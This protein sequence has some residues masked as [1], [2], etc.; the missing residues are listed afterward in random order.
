MRAFLWHVGFDAHD[1][2]LD[3]NHGDVMAVVGPVQDAVQRVADRT[4]IYSRA[5]GIVASCACIDPCTPAVE[6]VAVGSTH[7]GL[8]FD[9]DIYRMVG[10]RLRCAR[11][12]ARV[13]GA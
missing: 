2:G 7:L 8:G 11:P 3:R 4:A 13:S 6:H 1:R 10:E 5:D 9:P 12:S